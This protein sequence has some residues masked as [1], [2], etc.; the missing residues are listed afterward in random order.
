MRRLSEILAFP[1]AWYRR[2]LV[3]RLFLGEF[4]TTSFHSAATEAATMAAAAPSVGTEAASNNLGVRKA[5]LA[6][7]GAASAGKQRTTSVSQG[8][9]SQQARIWIGETTAHSWETLVMTA[10][11]FKELK[12]RITK[13]I[14]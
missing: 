5:T 8:E 10:I 13:Q 11:N 4:K 14:K 1:K 3:R 6:P 9:N 12:V 7:G 2:T